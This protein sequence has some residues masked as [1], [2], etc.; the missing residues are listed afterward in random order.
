MKIPINILCLAILLSEMVLAAAAGVVR[1]ILCL[2]VT[3]TASAETAP[4]TQPPARWILGEGLTTEWPVASD[5]RLPH[6]DT[7]EQGGL[8]VGQVVTYQIATNCTLTLERSVVWPGQRVLPNRTRASV[9][10]KYGK[11]TE[12][13]ITI[14]G[15]ATGAMTVERVV[16]DGTLNFQGRL[17]SDLI[18][19]RVTFPSPTVRT[20]VER[21]TL[22]N[23]G[24][25]AHTV[26]I[27]P[28]ARHDQVIGPY[29]LNVMEVSCTAPATTQLAPGQNLSFAVLF[30]A[31]LENETPWTVDAVQEETARR[32][33]VAALQQNLR[34]ETPEPE[35]D[36]QFAFCKLRVAEAINDTRGGMMLAP[37]G[38][39][40]YA[41]VWC[42]DNVE[43][44]APFFPFLGDTNANQASLNTFRMYRPF[45]KPDYGRIPAAIIAEGIDTISVAGDRGDAAMYAYGC[46]RFCLARGD[47]AIA[48]ELWPGIVWCLE[49][50]QR[51]MTPAGVIAS[52]SDEL[53]GRLPT[54]QANLSTST[55]AYGGLRSAANLA[56]ALGKSDAAKEY[57]HRAD[58]LAKAINDY[59][60]ATVEG[61][62]TY[63][64]YD[65]NDVLRSWICLPLCMGLMER[66]EG[67]IAALF[68]PRLW[69]SDGLLTQAGTKIFWDR[70]TLYGLRGVF[71]AGETTTGL[72][73]L[74][75]YT[76]RRLLGEHVPYP[77]EAW[78][79][80]NQRHLSSENALYCRIFTEGLFGILPTGL[81]EF[82]CTPRLPDGWPR[83]A[84]RS[85]RA[86]GRNFDVVVE[87]RQDRLQLTVLQAGR[88]VFDQTLAAGETAN[89]RLP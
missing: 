69:T 53:E 67:T 70:S 47:R 66:R 41:A 26:A 78:P 61:F 83:M 16:L 42:N 25:K 68:S 80:G 40:Y 55:L 62:S 22:R 89:I 74:T 52:Q 64:Y 34:L 5:A 37:G 43:Y 81:D 72:R 30:S 58:L 60:S 8:R 2:T 87:R 84:L 35:L 88:P 29:G 31:R 85:V 3:T 73:Y 1:G 32:A 23:A 11:E 63:R 12:P 19:T 59:F 33:H 86:F 9:I 44:A 17:G 56:R 77:V 10:H 27:T 65:G 45:M 48:E 79:E 20:A 18:A 6:Q 54:G 51:K 71:Q 4:A 38:L 49:Y 57:D 46:S 21:W 82:S 28:L 13:V 50:C 39:A 7:I 15:A 24:T 14:D 75:A 36:R 76:H